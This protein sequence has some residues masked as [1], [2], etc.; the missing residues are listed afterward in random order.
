[1][2]A[3]NFINSGESVMVIF[4]HGDHFELYDDNTGSTGNWTINSRHLV[5]RVIVYLRNK[6]INT[7]TVYIANYASVETT[8]EAGRYKIKLAHVQYVGTTHMN[9]YEF[10]GGGANPIRYLR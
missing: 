2:K 1:M 6:D 9:W 10:A 3:H 7:N 8:E 5:D 4:T